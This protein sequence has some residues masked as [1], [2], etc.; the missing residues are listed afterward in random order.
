MGVV[1]YCKWVLMKLVII[2]CIATDGPRL[3]RPTEI[4]K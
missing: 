3:T 4:C 1:L 2:G